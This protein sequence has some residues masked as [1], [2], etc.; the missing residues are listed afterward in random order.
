MTVAVQ[1]I[2]FLCNAGARVGGGHVMR[3]LTLAEALRA[4]GAVCAFAAGPEVARML[5]AFA[6]PEIERLPGADGDAEAMTEAGLL[7]I[8]DWGARWVVVDHYGLS[9]APE[10]RL[11]AAAG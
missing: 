6:G 11:R 2:L 1:R 9:A 5:A 4:K 10:A 7:A 8:D 3:S